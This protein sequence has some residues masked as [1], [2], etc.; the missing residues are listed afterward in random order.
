MLWKNLGDPFEVEV[1][2]GRGTRIS[3]TAIIE[4]NCEIGE[5][6]FIGQYVVMR[7]GTRI[8]NRTAI[9]HH[10]IF[11]GDTTVGDDCLIHDHS[12]ITMGSVIEDKV[13]IGPGVQTC[14][15]RFIVH[16]RH[17]WKEFVVEGPKIKHGARIGTHAALLPGV[18]IGEN[19][20]VAACSLV[21]KD[22]EPLSLVMG[23][24]AKFVKDIPEEEWI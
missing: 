21:T 2:V 20:M 14:N 6:C 22:V 12:Q 18:T 1:K 11:E 24:P 4:E 13:F 8:G 3:P 23:T 9:A 19:A 7:P 17:H 5:D 15:D 16:R 10:V